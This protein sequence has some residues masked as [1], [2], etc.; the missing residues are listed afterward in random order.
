MKLDRKVGDLTCAEVLAQLSAYL[1]GE[2]D[3]AEV[4]KMRVHVAGC[5]NCERF[6]GKFGAAVQGLRA[7]PSLPIDGDA[8]E[9]LCRRIEAG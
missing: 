5:V 3:K 7:L 2:L 1:D 6:G 9:A 8:L 4:E